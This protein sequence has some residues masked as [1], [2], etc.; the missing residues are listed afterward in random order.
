MMLL[1][2]ICS[3][4]SSASVSAVIYAETGKSGDVFSVL[5]TIFGVKNT[6][7]KVVT[8]VTAANTTLAQIVDA[9]LQDTKHNGMIEQFFVFHNQSIAPGVEF[10]VCTLVLSSLEL[11]CQN[12]HNSF[13]KR[14]EYL[15]LVLNNTK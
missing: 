12:G 11:V 9:S 6:T 7:G 13:T 8:F 10:K 1:I 15:E 4:L 3:V 2:A 14:A 5:V